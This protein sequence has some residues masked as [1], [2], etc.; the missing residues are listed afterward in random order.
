MYWI[1]RKTG[2]NPL[3]EVHTLSNLKDKLSYSLG[4]GYFG[5]KNNYQVQPKL[6]IKIEQMHIIDAH[7]S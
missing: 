2:H 3:F 4:K 6:E 7:L 5:P 1:P